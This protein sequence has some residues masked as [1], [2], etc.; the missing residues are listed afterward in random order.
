[1]NPEKGTTM[2]PMGPERPE[3]SGAEIPNSKAR[4]PKHNKT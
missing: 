4:K 3:A 1:M 2:E